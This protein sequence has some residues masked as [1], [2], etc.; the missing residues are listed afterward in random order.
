MVLGVISDTH[1]RL[2]TIDQAF[3]IFDASHVTT[4]IH[5]GDWTKPE[6]MRYLAEQAYAHD[7]A[8]YGVIGN[9]DIGKGLG[10]ANASQAHPV[11]F[12]DNGELLTLMLGGKRLHVYHGHHKPTLRRLVADT[13]YD[14]LLTGHTHKPLIEHEGPKLVIN[15]GSTAFSI[16]RRKE[17]R[18]VAIYDTLRHH[19]EL[20]YFDA[21]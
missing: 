10:E 14:L 21:L 18:T 20:V 8:L 6:T 7:M 19:A 4:L 11:M 9:R 15:P 5:C 16:P 1:D 17:A 13:S 3:E 2:A 12:P